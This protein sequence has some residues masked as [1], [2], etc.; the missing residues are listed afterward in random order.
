M[1]MA[2]IP[3]QNAVAVPRPSRPKKRPKRESGDEVS[4]A[5]DF[6]VSGLNW[7]TGTAVVMGELFYPRFARS[8]FGF[9][10]HAHVMVAENAF[11]RSLR[12]IRAGLDDFDVRIDHSP[13]RKLANYSDGCIDL[14]TEDD[15]LIVRVHNRGSAGRFAVRKLFTSF[16]R[17][18]LSV[19]FTVRRYKSFASRSVLFVTRADLHEVSL[20]SEG[21]CPG[22]RLLI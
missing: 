20:V 21:A 11:A 16:T 6:I 1:R 19:G 5:L 2:T 14:W 9:P 12:R 3:R 18:D 7:I 8:D 13:R 17:S 15:R 10:E 22:A 4:S